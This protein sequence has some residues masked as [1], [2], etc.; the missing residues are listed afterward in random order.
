MK[1]KQWAY[2]LAASC[3]RGGAHAGSAFLALATANYA[4]LDVPRLNLEAL[5]MIV[6]TSSLIEFFKF[7][8]ENPLPEIPDEQTNITTNIKPP[9]V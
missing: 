8:N 7:L 4:G 5:A 2:K 6:A 1:I 9:T 3:I